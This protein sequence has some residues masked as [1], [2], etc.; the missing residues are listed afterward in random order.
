[1][2]VLV[3]SSGGVDSSTCLALA[4]DKYGKESVSS[5]SVF[6]GQKHSKELK[7][8][9]D[10]ADYYGVKH[11]EIDLSTIMQ[12]SNCPLLSKSTQKIVHESYE[13]QV[14]ENSQGMVSTY[15][16]FRNGVLLSTVAAIAM[17]LYPQ[18]KCE[19]Y[20]G[21]HADD[22][23]G[24]AYADCTPQFSKAMYKAIKLGTYGNV[25]VKTPLVDLNKAGVVKIGLDLKV[26]YE[27][28]FSCYEGREK[29][30]GTCATCIDRQNAFYKNG[31]VDPIEYESRLENQYKGNEK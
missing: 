3:L 2:K 19:V 11:Y 21:I 6:Y 10:I 8:S 1:M 5:L 4:V 27:L 7:C 13:N 22:A 9:K 12:F 31:A 30:C 16:P 26:P 20:L 14:K 24:G 28:T 15:V 29:A 25:I 17:S 18:E 23:A